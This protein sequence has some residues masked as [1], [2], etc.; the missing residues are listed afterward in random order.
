M[1]RV[2]LTGDT[3]VP[4]RRLPEALCAAARGA[5]RVLHTG[6]V[7]EEAVLAELGGAVAVQGNCDHLPLPPRAVLDL[8]G[9]RVGLVHGHRGRGMTTLERARSA[10]LDESVQVIVFGHS[11]E[12]RVTW[13]DG[14]LLVNPGSPTDPR[15]AKQPSFAWLYIDGGRFDVELVQMPFAS[16]GASGPVGETAARACQGLTEPPDCPAGGA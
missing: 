12:P 7:L 11:H 5:D 14:I 4:P 2:L 6:D 1:M 16:E 8:D 3:H 10:F 15:R 9:V 13:L